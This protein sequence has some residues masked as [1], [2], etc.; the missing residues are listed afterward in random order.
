LNSLRAKLKSRTFV[1]IIRGYSIVF[2]V[3]FLVLTIAFAWLSAS[4]EKDTR[5]NNRLAVEQFKSA[6]DTQLSSIVQLSGKLAA[7]PA[8]ISFSSEDDL[9]ANLS[10]E[11]SF[12]I[13][14]D[15]MN[16]L[17]SISAANSAIKSA[18][19]Y[20]MQSDKILSSMGIWYSEDYY[21]VNYSNE[22]FSYRE[23]IN[24]LIN[25]KSSGFTN[26]QKNTNCYKLPNISYVSSI[27]YSRE[28]P[29]SLVLSVNMEQIFK[30]IEALTEN[31]AYVSII[32][33]DIS[34]IFTNSEIFN[35]IN[36]LKLNLR[37]KNGFVT[38]KIK[39]SKGNF[40]ISSQ[41]S[42][43]SHCTYNIAIPVKV[44]Y[45]QQTILRNILV[46]AFF[47]L[48]ISGIYMVIRISRNTFRPIE[49]LL[50]SLKQK[51]G[52]RNADENDAFE[53]I[54]T[55]ISEISDEKLSME[56]QLFLQSNT[57]SDYTIGRLM[58]GSYYSLAAVQDSLNQLNIRFVSDIFMVA[59][60][61]S[62][63]F[64][65]SDE[66]EIA[67]LQYVICNV[68]GE[69]FNG[70]Y[71]SYTV[72]MDGKCGVLINLSTEQ[73]DNA[74]ETI[75]CC[76]E[77]GREFISK[78]FNI[79]LYV[80]I[81]DK[82]CK[83]GGIKNAFIEAEQATELS[84]AEHSVT[85]V[86]EKDSKTSLPTICALTSELENKLTN[87]LLVG[88]EAGAKALIGE[89][90]SKVKNT[91][92][93]WQ[94]DVWLA[95]LYAA[96]MR[97]LSSF[98]FESGQIAQINNE[99]VSIM[100]D[101]K[102]TFSALCN[103]VETICSRINQKD[104]CLKS[105]GLA[106]KVQKYISENYSDSELT[107]TKIAD[108]FDLHVNYLSSLYKKKTGESIL[109]TIN[110]YRIAQAKLLLC[111]TRKRIEDIAKLTGYY[112]STA[113]IRSFKKFEGITPGQYRIMHSNIIC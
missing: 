3:P 34:T 90:N 35:E 56:K 21:K 62:D 71:L 100:Q 12:E 53:Y 76:V 36:S 77:Q 28:F 37:D 32:Y 44:Y 98:S 111:N 45:K 107:I 94:Y 109:D 38:Q 33:D 58:S 13:L 2:I 5:M 63:E 20:S 103:V 61:W 64:F 110:N 86:W 10:D 82:H 102:L 93:K 96:I 73:Q 9:L 17:A 49:N 54:R 6:L 8:V 29:I 92:Y 84:D 88:D 22:S 52:S 1:Y 51:G 104:I 68:F 7:A 16:E 75:K 24:Y 60:I 113:L 69:L 95:D 27:A 67:L 74:Y 72:K 40:I 25:S 48:L 78:H 14:R 31:G 87:M 57:M 43:L 11:H 30:Q 83:L 4:I 85:Y 108:Y 55:A 18:Y 106:E 81:S 15:F 65:G 66:D 59:L 79:N 47:S 39:T 50:A 41:Y 26:F 23:W 46:L 97:S 101:G 112:N 99:I 70:H 89:E 19:V 80:T 91:L 105:S 42:P